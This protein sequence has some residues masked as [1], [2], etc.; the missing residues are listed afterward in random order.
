MVDDGSLPYI[1]RSGFFYSLGSSFAASSDARFFEL[2][3]AASDS[4]YKEANLLQ[5]DL[6]MLD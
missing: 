1:V 3:G 6:C 5:T 4:G 2:I